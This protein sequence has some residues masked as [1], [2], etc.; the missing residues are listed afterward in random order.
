MNQMVQ[1]SRSGIE[2]MNGVNRYYIENDMDKRGY[3]QHGINSVDDSFFTPVCE[4][5]DRYNSENYKTEYMGFQHICSPRRMLSFDG[6]FD[7]FYH[8]LLIG[9]L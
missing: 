3:Q 6:F 4:K 2:M 9:R 1:K 8:F 5:A 7:E